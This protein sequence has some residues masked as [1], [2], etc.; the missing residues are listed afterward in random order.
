MFPQI[1]FCK[2]ILMACVEAKQVGASSGGRPG[3]K[4]QSVA[5]GTRLI[6]H[7]ETVTHL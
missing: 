4:P 6:G 5:A 3:K 1:Q 7:W 2:E